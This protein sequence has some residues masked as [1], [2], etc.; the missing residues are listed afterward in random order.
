MDPQKKNGKRWR[1]CRKQ[2]ERFAVCSLE[3]GVCGSLNL[4]ATY[5]FQRTTN[6]K[7]QT[8][9]VFNIV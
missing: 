7:P 6:Y 3:F 4:K 9:N 5:E 2:I 1:F 8:T